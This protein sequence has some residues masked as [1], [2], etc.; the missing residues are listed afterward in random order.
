M[1]IR[2]FAIVVIVL[3]YL[4]SL[5]WFASTFFVLDGIGSSSSY[6]P[7]ENKNNEGGSIIRGARIPAPALASPQQDIVSRSATPVVHI[8]SSR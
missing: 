1:R 3:V 7:H 4:G 2:N 6:K 8:V 5:W